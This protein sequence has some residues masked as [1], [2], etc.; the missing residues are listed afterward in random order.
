MFK[1]LKGKMVLIIALMI[2]ILMAGSSIAFNNFISDLIQVSTADSSLNSAEQNAQI[3]FEWLSG[4]K[5]QIED[6]ANAERVKSMNWSEQ[7]DFLLQFSNPNIESILIA[8][9]AGSG[10]ILNGGTIDISDR[11]Y[12]QEVVSTQATAISLP[13]TS[14]IS[15][16]KVIVIAVPIIESNNLVGVMA[17]TV[18]SKYLQTLINDMEIDG[19]GYGWIIDQQQRTIAHPDEQYIG[20]TDILTGQ[21]KLQSLT[22]RMVQGG[23]GVGEYTY[24]GVEK[25]LAYAPVGLAGWVVAMTADESDVLAE[26]V[27]ARNMSIWIAAIAVFI[28]IIITYFIASY[29]ANPILKAVKMADS[30]AKGNLA[31]DD[32]EIDRNDETGI[33]AASLNKMKENLNEILSKVT[34]IAENL[35]ASSQELSA[36]GEEVATAATQVGQSI[37]QVA[38]GAE[39]Q[40][41]QVEETTSKIDELIDQ[42]DNVTSMSRDMEAQADHVMNNIEGGNQSIDNSVD[43]IENVKGNTKEVANT[44]N[45]LGDLSN[46]IGEIVD[47]INNIAAQTNLLALNAAIEAA[48]AGDAGRGFSVVADE[49]RQLAE[50]SEAA[51]NQ[52]GGL[53]REIQSGVGSAVTRM[54]ATEEVVNGSVDAIKNTGKSFA[55]INSAALRLRDLIEKVNDRSEKVSANGKD[56]EATIKEI[57]SVSQEAASNAEEVA[58]ASQEQSASTEEIV[59]ASE[60]LTNMAVELTE[61]IKKFN[62]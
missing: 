37:Q 20:N 56:V 19:F 32:L 60:D 42:I 53:V 27:T 29:I 12:F 8:D 52:I 57:A 31:V 13:M 2:L 26:L 41:A 47:L 34:D 58:A 9:T 61:V 21:S 51:T 30:I 16:D 10:N 45:N 40:S 1:S 62:L 11:E 48:R 23:S 22:E 43:Q 15:G 54:D 5:T 17:G 59:S 49:I 24:N 18:K 33:L 7:S 35:S 44:I 6:F 55:E 4:L 38:S 39:E 14:R 36:S 46:K 50:E 25:E 3:I 28:G